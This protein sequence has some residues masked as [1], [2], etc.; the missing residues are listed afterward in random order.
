MPGMDDLLNYDGEQLDEFGDPVA[1]GEESETSPEPEDTEP[2]DQETEETEEGAPEETETE[3]EA[4]TAKPKQSPEEN[5]KF[6]EQRRQQQIQERVQAEIQKIR[7][8]DPAFKTA[9][10][11]EQMYGKPIDQIQQELHEAQLIREAQQR[12]VPVELLREQ[13]QQKQELDATRQQMIQL[14]FTMWRTRVE[15]EKAAL[16]SEYPMLSDDDLQQATSYIL[17]TLKNPEIPLA[18]AVHALHGQ[19]IVQAIRDNERNEALA[20]VSGRGKSPLPPQGGKS[21]P[22]NTLSAAERR[23]AEALGVSEEDYLKYK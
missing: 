20:K 1:A 8:E 4:P 21:S 22:T 14:Q 2:E 11:L 16:K 5:A 9:Q 7:Q 18:Q 10:L 3:T 12:G 17:D 13:Q 19:K 6:A 15:N 23:M